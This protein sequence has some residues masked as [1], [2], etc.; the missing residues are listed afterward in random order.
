MKGRIMKWMAAIILSLVMS[1]ACL[2]DGVTLWGLGESDFDSTQ[3]AL[4]GRVGYQM[5][6]WEA[7]LGSVWRPNFSVK[8][9]V[10]TEGVELVESGT[11]PNGKYTV[12]ELQ[13]TTETSTYSVEPPQVFCLG[14]L[15]HTNDLIDP[16]SP[17]PWIPDILLTILPEDLVA[18]PY[19]G[20]QV[21][22]GLFDTDAG[23]YGGIVGLLCKTNP[24]SKSSLVLEAQYNKMYDDL[25]IVP[26]DEVRLNVGFRF[27]FD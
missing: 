8:E 6:D 18:V 16:N 3:S 10:T 11:S 23:F 26:D 5:G 12:Y 21:T 24:E 22:V 7:F 13:Y 4:T 9:A 14:L 2:G 25:A 17:V 15:R 27:Y 20:A 19:A 1:V